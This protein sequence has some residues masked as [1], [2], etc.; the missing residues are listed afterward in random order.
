MG[1]ENTEQPDYQVGVGC[2]VDQL[3]GLFLAEVAGL[4]P[5]TDPAHLKTTLRSI[6]ERNYKR[7]M[8][9]HESVQRTFALNDEAAIVICDYG[10]GQRPHIPFPYFAEV[11]T[12]FEYCAATH[13]MYE[14]MTK[15]G[16]ECIASI[17]SRYDGERR[18]PWDEAECGHHYARAM[19]AWSGIL[20]LSGFR[21]SGVTGELLLLPRTRTAPFAS[22]WSAGTGWGTFAIEPG[23]VTV[24]VLF[25]ELPVQSITTRAAKVPSAVEAAGR[26]LR[27]SASNVKGA[28]TVK[29]DAPIRLKEK[30]SLIIRTA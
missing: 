8:S 27:H 23:K 25:G 3:V 19:A 18:N 15:E 14:G 29:L 24:T 10:P 12:G 21:H 22:F 9:A 5:L 30:E 4:G 7:D 13:M 26:P 16:Q 28:A 1:S 17:R 2:L 20:A 11:M 6:Y